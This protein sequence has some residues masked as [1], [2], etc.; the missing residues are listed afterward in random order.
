MV[1]FAATG[2][3]GDRPNSS[4]LLHASRRVW[5]ISGAQQICPNVHG[6]DFLLPKNA[7]HDVAGIFRLPQTGANHVGILFRLPKIAHNDV[8]PDF[9]LPQNARRHFREIFGSKELLPTTFGR[10][11]CSKKCSKARSR[12]LFQAVCAKRRVWSARTRPRFGPTRH[13]ASR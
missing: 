7:P 11:F 9:L 10:F 2:Q 13:V 5:R 3:P 1:K 12:H 6:T 8:R 4:L